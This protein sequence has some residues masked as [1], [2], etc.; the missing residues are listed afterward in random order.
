MRTE[1]SLDQTRVFGVAWWLM[2][3]ADDGRA[4]NY[5]DCQHTR[6]S[7]AAFRNRNYSAEQYDPDLGLYYLR[8]RY[9]DTMTG[10]F[11]SRDPEDGDVSDPKS[12]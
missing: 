3:Y 5:D 10:R 9:Y 4:Y 2:D 12:L 11:L 7:I 8:A 1:S 6:R